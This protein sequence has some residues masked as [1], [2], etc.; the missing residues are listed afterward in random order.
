MIGHPE[1]VSS[2]D[3]NST[4]NGNQTGGGIMEFKI[5][6]NRI[7]IDNGNKKCI[8]EVTFPSTSE[9]TVNVNHT[10]VD[11]SL[12]GQGIAN[13]LMTELAEHL[14]KTNRKAFATCYYA[15]DWFENHPEYSD[16]YII[17]E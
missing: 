3:L 5:E 14:R 6:K 15:I 7:Y 1:S 9:T 17:G 4:M 8:G 12:R 10:F 13:K 16:I 2:K 11:T